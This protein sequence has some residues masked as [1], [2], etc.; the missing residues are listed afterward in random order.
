MTKVRQ[1]RQYHCQFIAQRIG[2]GVFGGDGLHRFKLR[3]Q[4]L[5]HQAVQAPF[6]D[7]DL[8]IG[9][10]QL[11][12]S[13]AEILI[14]IS[15]QLLQC[16]HRQLDQRQAFGRIQAIK[17]RQNTQR[18]LVKIHALLAADHFQL[19]LVHKARRLGHQQ[20]KHQSTGTVGI[21]CGILQ[22]WQTLFTFRNRCCRFRSGRLRGVIATVGHA[23][24]CH[25]GGEPSGQCFMTEAG[26]PRTR[27]TLR[28]GIRRFV[29][30]G[31][32]ALWRLI[33]AIP[34]RLN[35]ANTLFQRWVSRKPA[36]TER[37]RLTKKQMRGFFPFRTADF[38][39]GTVADHF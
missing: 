11:H 38:G 5:Q 4:V 16:W 32:T 19:L 35:P 39:T 29:L 28:G 14:L 27:R 36:N 21:A 22:A 30:G 23:D 12:Q 17:Q 31:I 18:L 25:S 20:R 26:S 34:T 24:A 37:Q 10:G 7:I 6:K 33:A 15:R 13:L 1:R 2:L 3:I 9:F 8:T